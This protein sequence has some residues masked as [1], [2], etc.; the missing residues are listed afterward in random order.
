MV[1]KFLAVTWLLK[2]LAFLSSKTKYPTIVSKESNDQ[3]ER[4]HRDTLEHDECRRSLG[5][6]IEIWPIYLD[7]INLTLRLGLQMGSKI[8]TRRLNSF[9]AYNH[10]GRIEQ[11]Y[12][13][14]RRNVMHIFCNFICTI[15]TEV[16][17]N[18][19]MTSFSAW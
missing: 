7:K 2:T 11:N 12:C 14:V 19:P 10:Q 18:I 13:T 4:I 5:L 17:G 6:N 16:F 9:S 15:W 8:K 3:N 1:F